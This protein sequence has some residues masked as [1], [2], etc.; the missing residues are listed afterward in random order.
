MSVSNVTGELPRLQQL[1]AIEGAAR[2]Q[3]KRAAVR[4][5]P[6]E[7]VHRL[8]GGDR[9]E[10]MSLRVEDP[11]AAGSGKIEVALHVHLDAVERF[12]ARALVV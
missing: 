12:L 4:A 9:A 7:V 2:A 6:G 3:I 5:T 10:M 8:R 11:D 1:D